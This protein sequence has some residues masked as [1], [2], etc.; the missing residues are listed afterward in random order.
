MPYREEEMEGYLLFGDNMC[1]HG[2]L[3]FVKTHFSHL[4][5]N[6]VHRL[7]ETS[8]LYCLDK[9]GDLKYSSHQAGQYSQL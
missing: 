4:I 2:L 5:E 1:K 3:V 8:K 7:C 6:W 9:P